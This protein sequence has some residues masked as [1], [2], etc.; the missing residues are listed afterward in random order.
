MAYSKR[1]PQCISIL[2]QAAQVIHTRQR[3]YGHP[4]EDFGRTA[5]IWSAI[6]EV[7]VTA[8]QVALCLIGV[9]ISREC[10]RHRRDNCVDIAG[11][12][13]TLEMVSRCA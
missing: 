5:K 8:R 11:Y 6:L 12:A 7:P 4:A 2:Q 9:K 13:E 10:H 1:R 3:A